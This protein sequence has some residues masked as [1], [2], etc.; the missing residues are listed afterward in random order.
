MRPAEKPRGIEAGLLVLL[1]VW[2]TSGLFAN[3]RKSSPKHRSSTKIVWRTYRN[4]DLQFQMQVPLGWIFLSSEKAI[5]FRSHRDGTG[6]A[7]GVL[8]N[9]QEGLSIDKAARHEYKKQGRPPDWV[10]SPSTING[11]RALKIIMSAD[12]TRQKKTI[13]YY[14]EVP[15]AFYLIQST[16]PR[17]S[18]KRFAPLFDKMLASFEILP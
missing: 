2:P 9:D 6:A 16:A 14:V 12:A 15:E 5:G 11:R 4:E 3:P 7:I 13:Q 8:R 17:G 1:L 10:Q 18:W